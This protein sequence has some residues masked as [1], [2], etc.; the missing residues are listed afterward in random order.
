MI[1]KKG[2][3]MIAIDRDK[4]I[5]TRQIAIS[6]YAYGA[7]AVV[8]EAR[9]TDNRHVKTYYFS[10]GQSRPPGVVHD[11]IIRMVVKG[12]G[13]VIE[14]IDA[15]M[16]TVPRED[17]REISD[18]LKK[19]IGMKIQAGFTEKVK[20]KIGGAKGCTHLVALL[21][22]MAPAAVQG[23]WSAVSRQPV[24]PAKYSGPAL[25]FLEDTCWVWRSDG[26][27]MKETKAKFSG[28]EF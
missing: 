4:K 8:V 27:L 14:D 15:D 10:N 19:V 2:N 6:T 13:L 1:V 16:E 26:E 28:F 9:L 3:Q 11:L 5:H 24:D 17:C 18:A 22:A 25:R 23:S 20:A 7:E 12:A 21:L